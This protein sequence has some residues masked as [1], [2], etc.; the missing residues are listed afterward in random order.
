M[1]SWAHP[2]RE[3]FQFNSIHI[4]SMALFVGH[5][6]ICDLLEQLTDVLITAALET[7]MVLHL[8]LW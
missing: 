8:L 3:A 4:L 6:E 5:D 7:L 2:T 1:H